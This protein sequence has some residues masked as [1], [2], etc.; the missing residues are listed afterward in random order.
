MDDAGWEVPYVGYYGVSTPQSYSPQIYKKGRPIYATTW[1][2]YS[3]P[4]AKE[5]L[6]DMD[7]ALT[8]N[9]V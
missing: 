2:E 8:Y 1:A 5:M 9:I 7:D 4:D 3:S 6:A